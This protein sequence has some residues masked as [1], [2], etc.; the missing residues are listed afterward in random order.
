MLAQSGTN[1]PMIGLHVQVGQRF[2]PFECGFLCICKVVYLIPDDHP[3]KAVAGLAVLPR[4]P[5]VHL[6]AKTAAIDLGGPK[7]NQ[8]ADLRIKS[9]VVEQF[10][11]ARH[12][13]E[14]VRDR[15]FVSDC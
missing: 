5:Y 9:I 2:G 12:R 7:L 11:H 14:D 1:G 15:L 8:L 13:L 10:M 3:V 6:D 4:L